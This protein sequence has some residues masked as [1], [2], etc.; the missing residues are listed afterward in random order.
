MAE[1]NLIAMM[2]GARSEFAFLFVII[3]GIASLAMSA[4]GLFAAAWGGTCAGS[5][6]GDR[7]LHL[8]FWVL[9][10]LSAVA[11]V[12]YFVSRKA[13]LFAAWA[14]AIGSIV[15]I[16]ILNLGSCLTGECTTKNPV[17]IALGVFLLPHIW[18]LLVASLGLQL[19]TSISGN[20]HTPA[21]KQTDTAFN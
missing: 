4:F 14:I 19:A 12:S 6:I 5:N 10:T 20:Y 15:T 18:F 3:A 7:A 17:K 2:Q 1:P 13:G 21:E 9:P 11:F 16:F 8:L